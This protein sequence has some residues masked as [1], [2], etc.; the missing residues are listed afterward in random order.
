MKRLPPNIWL[1]IG[2]IAI[3][4]ALAVLPFAAQ[5]GFYFND[6][7]PLSG[8][9]AGVDAY[10]LFKFERPGVGHLYDVTYPLLGPHPLAWQFFT[11][12][13]RLGGSF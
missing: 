9:I 3:V 6:W 7:H 8:E 12:A 2:L 4:S 11:F 1:S 13:L 10:S 5:M